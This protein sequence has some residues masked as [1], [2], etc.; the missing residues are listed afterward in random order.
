MVNHS[1]PQLGFL[2]FNA[3]ELIPN[4]RSC[5]LV[6][7]LNPVIPKPAIVTGLL[8]AAAVLTFAGL[9]YQQVPMSTTQTLT[10]QSTTTWIEHSHYAG[11]KTVTY[12]TTGFLWPSYTKVGLVCFTAFCVA[13]THT[14]KCN[15]A[16]CNVVTYAT[17]STHALQNVATIS[18][19]QTATTSITENSTSLVPAST[20][21]GLTDGSF[22]IL[23]V[24]V[25]GILALLTAWVELKPRLS[26]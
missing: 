26:H 16:A 9:A 3:K 5:I 4:A 22:T 12:T 2:E 8:L 25:I 19:S 15:H 14:L 10:Q 23:A 21:L 11:V 17:E 20:V 18:H 7:W 6:R 1:F 24:T 13:G